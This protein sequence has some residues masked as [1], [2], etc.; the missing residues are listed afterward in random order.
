M[1]PNATSVSMAQFVVVFFIFCLCLLFVCLFLL[2]FLLGMVRGKEPPKSKYNYPNHL[3]LAE[4]S[5]TKL[6]GMQLV[7]QQAGGEPKIGSTSEIVAEGNGNTVKMTTQLQQDAQMRDF[8]KGQKE[9]M[10]ALNNNS[11]RALTRTNASGVD[12]LSGCQIQSEIKTAK[13]TMKG[14]N[15]LQFCV[16]SWQ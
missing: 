6:H 16:N 2:L 11:L 5:M 14:T 9:F 4:A 3:F 7:A 13:P 8:G 12:L 10:R 1:Y 15:V